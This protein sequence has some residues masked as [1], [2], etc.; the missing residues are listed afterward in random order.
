MNTRAAMRDEDAEKV[1]ADKWA[2]YIARR[3]EFYSGFPPCWREFLPAEWLSEQTKKEALW[4]TF[5][6]FMQKTSTRNAPA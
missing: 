2:A 4:T 5:L 6:K 3:N 1:L